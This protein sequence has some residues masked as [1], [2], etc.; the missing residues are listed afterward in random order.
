MSKTIKCPVCTGDTDEPLVKDDYFGDC[1]VVCKSYFERKRNELSE[2]I[3][4]RAKQ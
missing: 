1:C 2:Y 4:I 3:D